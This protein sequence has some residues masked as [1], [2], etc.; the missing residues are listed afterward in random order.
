M[1]KVID[2]KNKTIG[3][4]AT[5]AA[6]ALMGK[7]QASYQPNV[8][9]D[10]TVT[11][12]NASESNITDKKKGEKEYSRYSGYPGG[13]KVRTLAEVIEKKGYKEVFEKA[14][15]GMLPANRLRSLRMKNLIIKD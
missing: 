9:T 12:E 11:I 3:R 8:V 4:V 10:I 15:Y 1:E 6:M 5:E 13:R 2:A 7:D 14:V